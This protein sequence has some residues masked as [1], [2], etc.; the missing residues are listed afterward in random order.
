MDETISNANEILLPYLM[1]YGMNVLGA[2]IILIIGFW[3]AGRVKKMVLKLFTKY[4]QLDHT[5]GTFL[6]SLA[7]YTIIVVTILAVLQKFGFE[8]TSLLAVLGAA[9]LAVGLALQGTLSN[10]AAGVMLMIFQP[11]R[12]GDFVEAGGKSGTV[13]AINLFITEL[14]TGDNIQFLI[15]N[16][17]IWGNAITNVSAHPT[18]RVDITMGVSYDADINAAMNILLA[19]IGEDERIFKDPEPFMG[20]SNL[21]DSSVD[22]V[23]RVWCNASDYWGVK[24]A[25]TKKFKEQFDAN[26]I[27]I[28][29][30]TRT[31]YSI[32][33]TS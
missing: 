8:T 13:K 29:F 28:P 21:G 27:D 26:G 9:G 3:I 20:V 18:R 6:A 31:V 33:A 4:E 11:F 14:A 25:L 24:F 32:N 12:I 16:G 5:L 19:T 23:V 17:Q 2:L 7:R 22:I 10:L 1:T 30:P 15:P